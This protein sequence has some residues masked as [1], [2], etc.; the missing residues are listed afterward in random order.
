M[1]A[2]GIA[3]YQ[4]IQCNNIKNDEGCSRH[5]LDPQGSLIMVLVLYREWHT[6]FPDFYQLYYGN[7]SFL[8]QE[9]T[10][11]IYKVPTEQKRILPQGVLIR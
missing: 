4:S 3:G 10:R 7:T 8:S 1:Q 2:R 6:T 9:S 11:I 5:F